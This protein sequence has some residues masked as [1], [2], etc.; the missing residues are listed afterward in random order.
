MRQT[1]DRNGTV[2]LR[3]VNCQ[4]AQNCS[5][6]VEQMAHIYQKGK[7]LFDSI[8]IF[9]FYRKGGLDRMKNKAY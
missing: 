7:S 1:H 8:G 9:V 3:C 4:H 2:N 6:R 5:D